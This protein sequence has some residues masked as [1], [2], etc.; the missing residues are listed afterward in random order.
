MAMTLIIYYPA[1]LASSTRVH[2]HTHTLLTIITTE[3]KAD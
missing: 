3:L 1:V 2:T